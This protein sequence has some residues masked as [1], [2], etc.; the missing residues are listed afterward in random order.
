M[1]IKVRTIVIWGQSN[2]K[3]TTENY[4]KNKGSQF[5]PFSGE[6]NSNETL[7]REEI[8]IPRHKWGIL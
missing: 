2:I 7:M 1:Q 4:F 3:L 5:S 8:H 6:K